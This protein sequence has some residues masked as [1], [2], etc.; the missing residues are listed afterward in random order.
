MVLKPDFTVRSVCELV[1]ATLERYGVRA[2]LVDLDDTLVASGSA[3]LATPFQSWVESLKVQR[4]PVVILSN[5]KPERVRLWSQTLGVPGFS[6][7]GKPFGFAYRRGLRALGTSAHETAMVG[8]QLFTDILGANL[9]GLTSILVTPLSSGGLPHTRLA[10]R[11]EAVILK[12]GPGGR[13][14]YWG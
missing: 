13:S 1:P 4:V 10:R 14:L 11:L 2:L 6:L 9:A 8:D 5:G 3:D 7:T 12:G